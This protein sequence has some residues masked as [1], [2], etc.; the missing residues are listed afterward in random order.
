MKVKKML[1]LIL[2]GAMTFSLAA[3]GGG[4]SSGSSDAAPAGDTSTTEAAAPSGGGSGKKVGIAM[5]TKSLERW[6]RDGS[7]LEAQF[8]AAGYATEV[9]YSDNEIKKQVA[10]IENLLA[11]GVDLLVIAAIDGDSLTQVLT[12]AKDYGIP[13]ISYDRLIRGTDA[14]SYY[15]S[16]DNYK[17]GELQGQYVI[18]TLGLDLNDT[19]KTYNIEFTAGDPADNNA[20]FFF[21]GAFDTLKPYIDAGILNVPSGQTSFEQVATKEWKT[22]LAMSRMQNILGSNYGNGETLDVALCSNDST[23]LGVTKAIETDY[24]GGNAVL[25]TGQDGDE[26]NL[27]NIVDGKQTM[28]VYKAVANEAVATL[29]LGVKLLEG[30]TPDEGLITESNWDF[31]CDYNTT[32][33]DNGKLVVPSYLLVPTVVTKDNLQEELVDTGYYVMDGN[34]PKSAS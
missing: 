5:P 29:D 21:N 28:T 16:F 25:I 26:P 4:S 31:E 2:A 34:Y 33:Y 24:A 15:V 12:D 3:C 1:A 8:K 27:A 10:D 7:F 11:G 18:D 23:A 20:T 32:D 17:V 6:N 9:T 30:E 19:S 13:V 14:V 22:D